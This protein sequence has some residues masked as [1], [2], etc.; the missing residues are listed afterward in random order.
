M[1]VKR[2]LSQAEAL[3]FMDMGKDTF[4]KVMIDNK[5]TVR[6]IGAKKYYRVGQLNKMIADSEGLN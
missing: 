3:A 1:P 6:F 5:L 4:L 2:W